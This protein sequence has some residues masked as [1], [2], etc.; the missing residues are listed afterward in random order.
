MLRLRP[1]RWTGKLIS[2]RAWTR[3]MT[4]R[5]GRSRSLLGRLTHQSDRPPL[6][7]AQVPARASD[8]GPARARPARCEGAEL[9]LTVTIDAIGNISAYVADARTPRHSPVRLAQSTTVGTGGRLDGLTGVLRPRACRHS[10]RRRLVIATGGFFPLGGGGRFFSWSGVLC[11]GGGGGGGVGGGWRWA[12]PTKRA[13][14]FHLCEG[15]WA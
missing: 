6:E 4:L 8:D 2:H 1:V 11:L 10:K 9:G 7:A 13:R 15:G 3:G 5:P 12:F 14:V